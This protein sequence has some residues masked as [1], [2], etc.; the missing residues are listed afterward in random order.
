M[1]HVMFA[2]YLGMDLELIHEIRFNSI[3]NLQPIFKATKNDYSDKMLVKNFCLKADANYLKLVQNGICLNSAE[4]YN[5]NSVRGIILT[6]NESDQAEPKKATKKFV[7][8]FKHRDQI[9]VKDK[10]LDLVYVIWSVDD[11]KTWKYQ[12]TM[13]KN[14][15][16]LKSSPNTVIKTHEFFIQDINQ[17]IDINNKFQL[18]VCHQ[19][20]MD[21]YKD[22][23]EDKC[24]D[25]KCAI[26]I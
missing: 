5:Q 6:L 3:H 20:G 9:V 25:F 17:L 18:I 21:V 22:T 14:S 24:F 16:I 15:K 13:Q 12:L 19:I 26:K 1:K 23:N 11:W 4:I 10:Q 2:D 7:N 8:F